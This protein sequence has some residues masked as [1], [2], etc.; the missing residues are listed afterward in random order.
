MPVPLPQ[1]FCYPGL[2]LEFR[3]LHHCQCINRVGAE[4]K[5]IP[6]QLAGLLVPTESK[7]RRIYSSVKEEFVLLQKPNWGLHTGTHTVRF[8]RGNSIRHV[9]PVWLQESSRTIGNGGPTQS[10]AFRNRI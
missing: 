1:R 9:P 6:S 8:E 10:Q 2:S 3:S 7:R 4:E 5:S